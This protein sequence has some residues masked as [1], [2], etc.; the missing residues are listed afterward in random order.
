M[1]FLWWRRSST[2]EE[3]VFSFQR[4]LSIGL[5]QRLTLQLHCVTSKGWRTP[6]AVKSKHGKIAFVT[7][8]V[9]KFRV[10]P[11]V[12]DLPKA[13]QTP[14]QPAATWS[15]LQ[16]PTHRGRHSVEEDA[17]RPISLHLPGVCRGRG[18]TGQKLGHA[19]RGPTALQSSPCSAGRPSVP[20]WSLPD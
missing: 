5:V 12:L 14:Q 15:C 3:Y 11:R 8:R 1:K 4:L 7:I 9:C 6:S 10:Y 16:R 20:L 13:V 19:A 18:S 17:R 2:N